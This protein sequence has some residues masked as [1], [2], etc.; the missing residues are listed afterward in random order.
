MAS[1]P[2]FCLTSLAYLLTLCLTFF[3]YLLTFF[4]KFFPASDIL[5][6][7]LSSTSSDILSNILSGISS[8]IVSGVLSGK[9][10]A[11]W[12]RCCRED[13]PRIKVWQGKQCAS[14]SRKRGGGRGGGERRGQRGREG[15]DEADVNL[16]TLI[17]TKPP[18]FQVKCCCWF[19]EAFKRNIPRK[20]GS[21][22]AAVH[23]S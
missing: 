2:A 23:P 7:G 21:W 13:C 16:Y 14:G 5:S 17:W 19:S 20:L 3:A 6:D 11:S 1:L 18:F 4:L 12:L 9:S 22:K 8:D 15:G 10:S